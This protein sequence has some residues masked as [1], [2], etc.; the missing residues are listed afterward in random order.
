MNRQMNGLVLLLLMTSC[1]MAY[2]NHPKTED[3]IITLS[4]ELAS[5][6][7]VT[8]STPLLWNLTYKIVYMPEEGAWVEMGD[9]VVI[10]DTKEVEEELEEIQ[11]GYERSQKSLEAN[12]LSNR[13]TITEI[14][15]T[16]KSLEIQKQIVINQVQQSKYNS[17]TDQQDAE[18]ELKKVE[19]NILKTRQ[20]LDSQKIINTNTENELRIQLEQSEKRIAEFYEILNNMYVTS[21]KSGIIVYQRQGRRGNGEKVKVG[22]DIQ[23]GSTILKI[24]D[25]NNMVAKVEL[26]EVDLTKIE[27]GQP[28][29]ICVLAYPDTNFSGNVQYISKIADKNDDSRLRIYP[30]DIKIDSQRNFRLKPGLTVKIDLTIDHKENFF[31]IPSWCLF[32]NHENFFVKVKSKEIPVEV[33]NIYDGKA[34]VYGE[35]NPNMQLMENQTIPNF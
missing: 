20:A 27:I 4:G 22:D 12:L 17:E 31:S 18:L 29:S 6:N 30:V 8:I 21:P 1:I 19:L 15:N 24:P 9:T 7:S 33:L 26:N 28:A 10:F 11:Q 25:L 13:Q 3:I 5:E 2:D 32:K 23:P 16:I 14:E 34:Y 35:L